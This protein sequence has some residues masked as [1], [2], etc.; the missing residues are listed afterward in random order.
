MRD[1]VV[2]MGPALR[3]W[4]PPQCQAS[5][6]KAPIMQSRRMGAGHKGKIKK[7]VKKSNK[8]KKRERGEKRERERAQRPKKK[9]KRG[10]D[11]LPLPC[12]CHTR[13]DLSQI[14]PR[15]SRSEPAKSTAN[16]HSPTPSWFF[17][18]YWSDYCSRF[19]DWLPTV[20]TKSTFRKM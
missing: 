7:N 17:I 8:G 15:E 1:Q 12:Y 18:R 2:R 14:A 5:R 9:I 19:N 6:T 3:T 11:E 20:R 10:K 13:A 4:S 16:M